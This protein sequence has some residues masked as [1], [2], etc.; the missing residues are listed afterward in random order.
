MTEDPTETALWQAVGAAPDDKLPRLVLADF[1]DEW[2]AMVACG[3]GDGKLR[4]GP[5]LL[6]WSDC[7]TCSGTGYVPDANGRTAAALRATADRVPYWFWTNS[8]WPWWCEPADNLAAADCVGADV[9]ELLL[10][11]NGNTK[12]KGWADYP[13]A[14][15]AIR[16]LCA[17]YCVV[18]FK[19]EVTA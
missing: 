3:C 4:S 7:P 19:G 9:G 15:A 11:S 1:L 2:S 6:D 5:W 18:N 14:S 8:C 16:D 12:Q 10:A 13:T 17:A